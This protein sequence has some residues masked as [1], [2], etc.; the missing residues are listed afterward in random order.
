MLPV[1]IAQQDIF[2]LL[3]VYLLLRTIVLLA[4]GALKTVKQGQQMCAPSDTGAL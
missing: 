1:E 4:T 2:V 3:A